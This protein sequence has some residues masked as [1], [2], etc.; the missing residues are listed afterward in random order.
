[1]LN[2]NLPEIYMFT[3]SSI[4]LKTIY[5]LFNPFLAHIIS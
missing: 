4:D 1:M 2:N 5:A 3:I